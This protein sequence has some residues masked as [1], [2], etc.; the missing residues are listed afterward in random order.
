MLYIL[1]VL[2]L[3]IWLLFIIRKKKLSWH[4]I[5]NVYT[6]TYLAVD[7]PEAVFNFFFSLYKFISYTPDKIP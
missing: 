5:V 4:T 7:F 6:L 2:F 1:H 3:L